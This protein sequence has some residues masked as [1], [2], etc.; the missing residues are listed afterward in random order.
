ME[1]AQK[2][3][4]DRKKVVDELRTGEVGQEYIFCLVYTKLMK[5]NKCLNECWNSGAQYKLDDLK[6]V[7]KDWETKAKG[8]QK[9]MEDLSKSLRHHGEQ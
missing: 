8:Y 5:Q 6:K 7:L 2:E 3:Y 1:S 9:Q 4:N